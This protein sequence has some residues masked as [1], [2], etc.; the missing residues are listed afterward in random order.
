MEPEALQS[1][2]RRREKIAR[3]R[4]LQRKRRLVATAEELA[5]R[6]RKMTAAIKASNTIRSKAGG[7]PDLRRSQYTLKIARVNGGEVR[8]ASCCLL[9]GV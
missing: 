7:T 4:Q 6:K 9:R 8:N 2:W 3:V 1:T 5:E